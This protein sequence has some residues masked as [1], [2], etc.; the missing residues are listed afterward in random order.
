MQH[1]DRKPRNDNRRRIERKPNAGKRPTWFQRR[2]PRKSEDTGQSQQPS[3]H[4]LTRRHRSIARHLQHT[5][6]NPAKD[7]MPA[8][9]REELEREMHALDSEIRERRESTDAVVARWKVRKL[10]AEAEEER[11]FG[12]S[13]T[14][15]RPLELDASSGEPKV[16]TI[17]PRL[18]SARDA[19]G[20]EWTKA[21]MKIIGKYHRVRF[22]DRQKATKRLKQARKRLQL[23]ELEHSGDT[24]FSNETNSLRDEVHQHEIDVNYAIYFP[25]LQPYSSL[26]PSKSKAS[27]PSTSAGKDKVSAGVQAP[28]RAHPMWPEI[29]RRTAQGKEALDDL[30]NTGAS[31]LRTAKEV[32]PV[33]IASSGQ[34]STT[35]RMPI[36]QPMSTYK[37]SN[38]SHDAMEEDEDTSDGGFFE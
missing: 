32:E 29:E 3:L 12:H 28:N 34:N 2:G 26:W 13:V 23:V 20:K 35:P 21:E 6:Q 24:K 25:L 17:E 15:T 14:G 22:F 36:S 30:R 27:A 19:T 11:D 1:N 10:R 18:S 16:P 37:A 31:R 9:V 5:A 33:R 38:A 4:S 8:S 7:T